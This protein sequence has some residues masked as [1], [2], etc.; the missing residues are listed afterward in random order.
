M[1]THRPKMASR[2]HT[3]ENLER[4]GEESIAWVGKLFDWWRH[5]NGF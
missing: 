3:F 2:V 5:H 4:G 1:T